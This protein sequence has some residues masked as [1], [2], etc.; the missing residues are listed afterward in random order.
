VTA[1]ER[2][3]ACQSAGCTTLSFV[4]AIG[5]YPPWEVRQRPYDSR[6]PM[7]YRR[8]ASKVANHATYV[9]VRLEH[10]GSTAVPGLSA[11]PIVDILIGLVRADETLD[12]AAHALIQMG[13]RAY[14]PIPGAEWRMLWKRSDEVPFHV[15]VVRWKTPAWNRYLAFRDILRQHPLLARKYGSLKEI[16]AR[17]FFYDVREYTR[18]KHSFESIALARYALLR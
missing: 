8:E 7:Y 10:I 17:R 1:T 6:W 5:A 2:K 15:H 3:H 13:Y 16:L 11:K 12:D 4:D 9:T 14:L 18:V